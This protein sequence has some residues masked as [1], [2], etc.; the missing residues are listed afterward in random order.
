MKTEL[1]SIVNKIKELNK[2]IE[3]SKT[4]NIMEVCGTHTMA[5]ARYGIQQLLPSNINLISGPGCPVCVTSIQDID[6][7]L[8]I[9]KK[10]D[11]VAFSFG[12]LFKVPGTDSSLGLEKSKGRKI[13]LC[14]SPLEA[15]EYALK[16]KSE[17]ILFISIG[18]ET[19]APLTS[20]LIKRAHKEKI[21]NFFIFSTHKII[22]PALKAL[23]DDKEVKIDGLL[24]PGHVSAI[25]GTGPFKFIPDKYKMPC[26]VTG[27]GAHDVLKAVLAILMQIINGSASVEIE[28]DRVVRP[29]GN[30]VALKLLDITFEPEDSYWRGIGR[31]AKSGLGIKDEFF[32]LDAK[33]EFPVKNLNSKEPSGCLCGDILK[34]IKKPTDCRLFAKTCVPDDPVGP[35]MVSSEGTCAAYFKYKRHV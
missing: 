31:I 5:I 33:K 2:K 26:V 32:F 7:Y 35:C 8:E 22:P 23:L 34:G 1:K 16:N 25:T 6:W 15:I 9:V 18:F 10:E 30:P 12:D 27:F 24:L 19:T 13:H 21:R 29:E 3:R 17:K 14:Y 20:V 11:V 28:Y 4:I